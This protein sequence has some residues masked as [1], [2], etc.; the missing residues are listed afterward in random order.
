MLLAALPLTFAGAIAVRVALRVQ[1]SLRPA[2]TRVGPAPQVLG[3]VTDVRLVAA[4]STILRGW[5]VPSRNRAAVILAHGWGG[6]RTHLLPEARALARAGYGVL[7]FDWRA[8][9][10][11]GGTRT[12]WGV[13]EQQ[14]LEAAIRNVAARPDVD[15]QRIGAL[16]F[17]MGGMVVAQV[18]ERDPRLRGVMIQGAF[19]SLEDE[20]RH[21]EGHWGWWSGA[22]GVWT[23]RAAGIPI[24]RERPID[25]LCRISP[26]PFAIVVGEVDH[27][28]PVSVAQRMFTA[29]CAPKELWIIPGADHLSYAARAGPDYGRRVVAFFDGALRP[30]AQVTERP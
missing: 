3:A 24:D 16:G 20:M 27:D 17:S 25:H 26:R 9:G 1:A 22:V 7:L 2:R 13:E 4:D 21:D 14:D 29:A 15:P 19:S 12:T 30:L 23:L 18:A 11:S 6:V 5:Y 8:H 10:E 28:L